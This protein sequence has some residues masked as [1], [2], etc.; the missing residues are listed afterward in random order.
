[1]LEPVVDALREQG[2]YN[3]PKERKFCGRVNHLRSPR[4]ALRVKAAET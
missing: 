2:L 3:T 4:D 1:M